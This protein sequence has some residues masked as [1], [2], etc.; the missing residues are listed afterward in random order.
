MTPTKIRNRLEESED[1]VDVDSFLD[2][3]SYVRDDGR[4]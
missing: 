2:A 4:N 3:L 1:R